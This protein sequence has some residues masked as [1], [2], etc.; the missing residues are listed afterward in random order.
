MTA[1]AFGATDILT[2]STGW[3]A[4]ES[5]AALAQSRATASGDD[6]DIVAE[7][8]YDAVQSGTA[9]YIYTGAE[10]DFAAAL[11]AASAWPGYLLASDTLFVTG[12]SI[13]YTRCGQGQRPLI[14]FSYRNG[15]TAAPATPYWYLSA[16]TLPT[17]T[18]ANVAIPTLLTATLGDAECVG[19][20]WSLACQFGR[21]LDK[22]GAF[23]YGNGY[24]GE[25]TINLTFVGVPTS[26]TSTGW[27]QTA[28]EATAAAS[29]ANTSYPTRNYSYVRKVARSTGA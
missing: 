4:Q 1:P 8:A 26:V 24:G 29:T 6:G 11:T 22:S 21:D 9:G 28:G 14:T 20:T 25:E 13:D 3:E 18:A 15:P 16:L 19:C 27:I 23:L 12:V 2:L 7:S 17:Y 10:T 5:A